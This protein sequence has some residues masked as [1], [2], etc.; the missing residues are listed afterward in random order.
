VDEVI[1]E[2]VIQRLE[3]FAAVT[4]TTGDE[5]GLAK[6]LAPESEDEIIAAIVAAAR[7]A[8]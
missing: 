2:R 3:N 7:M 4:G 5:S 8:A 1:K 6:E